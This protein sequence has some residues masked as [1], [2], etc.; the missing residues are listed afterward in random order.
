MYGSCFTTHKS[1][2][3]LTIS[4]DKWSHKSCSHYSLVACSH[5][6]ARV[7]ARVEQEVNNQ[8]HVQPLKQVPQ[9]H[10]EQV[11]VPARDT[12]RL[13]GAVA[14]ISFQFR[15]PAPAGRPPVA[16]RAGAPCCKHPAWQSAPA[17]C[18]P[19]PKTWPC[20]PKQQRV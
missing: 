13:Q 7:H 10:S 11:Q 15:P 5:G 9:L 3:K 17:T 12:S 6:S 20:G 2:I 16:C 19:R 18:S 8:L 1:L 4:V 14:Y